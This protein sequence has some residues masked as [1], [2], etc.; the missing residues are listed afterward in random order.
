MRLKTYNFAKIRNV[1]LFFFLVLFLFILSCQ[2]EDEKT[3]QQSTFPKLNGLFACEIYKSWN[4]GI[5]EININERWDFD[6][7]VKAG[8]GSNTWSYTPEKGWT[9]AS[10]DWISLDVEWKVENGKFRYGAWSDLGEPS[11]W[12][13][14]DFEYI[15]ENSFRLDTL[16]FERIVKK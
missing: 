10:K 9:N 3:I 1:P 6:N 7:T 14:H 16:I 5:Y 8:Y 4:S 2:K 13:S 11:Y 15:D 12:Y